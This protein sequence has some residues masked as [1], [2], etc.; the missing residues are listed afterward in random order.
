MTA[1]TKSKSMVT[2]TKTHKKHTEKLVYVT[3]NSSLKVENSIFDAV[4]EGL[5]CGFTNQFIANK[6]GVT[7][8]LV[9]SCRRKLTKMKLIKMGSYGSRE[10]VAD[11]SIRGIANLK[12]YSGYWGVSASNPVVNDVDLRL[13]KLKAES[14][15][16]KGEPSNFYFTESTMLQLIKEQ[17]V[18]TNEAK[19]SMNGPI[20]N[21][22]FTHSV[23]ASVLP[24]EEDLFQRY[25]EA[26]VDFNPKNS[27]G[28]IRNLGGLEALDSYE[29]EVMSRL[30]D[31]SKEEEPLDTAS[32]VTTNENEGMEVLETRELP[33]TPSNKEEVTAKLSVISLKIKGVQI[34]I[35]TD[36]TSAITINNDGI[37]I[38]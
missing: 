18:V 1:K 30:K 6:M 32:I 4:R 26:M 35:S 27:Y 11:I 25:N 9:D 29:T 5:I 12:Y 7:K 36:T 38:D 16:V 3:I 28:S 10:N 14:V 8:P 34:N 31:N 19:I 2:T 33:S 20:I 23:P 15:M 21:G 24:S 37:I 22:D 17:N 13:P